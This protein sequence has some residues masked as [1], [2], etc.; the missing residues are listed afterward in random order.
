METRSANKKGRQPPPVDS[1]EDDNIEDSPPIDSDHDNTEYDTAASGDETKDGGQTSRQPTT[2]SSNQKRSKKV[3]FRVGSSSCHTSED[4]LDAMPGPRSLKEVK[5]DIYNGDAPIEAYIAQFR[6]AAQINCWPRRDWG[7]QLA[8]R[9]R[10]EAR[11]LILPEAESVPPTFDDAVSMLKHRFGETQR[12]AYYLTQLRARKRKEKESIP[13]LAQWFRRIGARAYPKEDSA[14]RDRVLL[15]PFV[16]TLGDKQMRNYIYEKEPERLEDAVAAA[17]RYE[18][19]LNADDE[20]GKAS[21]NTVPEPDVKKVRVKALATTDS[22]LLQVREELDRMREQLASTVRTLTAAPAIATLATPAP[23][24]MTLELQRL[25]DQVA[26]L[27][28]HVE[29]GAVAPPRM[30]ATS[31]QAQSS[32]VGGEC[33]NCGRKGHFQRDCPTQVICRG[34]GKVGHIERVCRA[35]LFCR[36]CQRNGHLERDCRTKR[37]AEEAQTQQENLEGRSTMGTVRGRQD[38]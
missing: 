10:G 28:M 3:T 36:Y 7:I 18:A 9:L 17:L 32:A 31:G 6:L 30:A 22:D 4:K 38:Q 13:E 26:A 8:L 14:T 34:C 23:A 11:N 20:P 33:F 19:I 29:Q 24:P 16:R 37:S 12:P 27:R 15:D 35:K 1:E 2:S 25:S 5:V 21:Q